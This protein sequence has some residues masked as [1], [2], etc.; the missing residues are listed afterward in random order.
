MSKPYG[1]ELVLDLKGC[2]LTGLGREQVQTFLVD[3]CSLIEMTRHGE[4]MFWEDDSGIEHLHGVSAVQFIETSTVVCHC[5][6]LL[7]AVY[8]N[9]FSC[10]PFDQSE[11]ASFC[12]KFWAAGS[13]EATTISRG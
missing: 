3:L 12:A 2:A 13:V 6:P 10:K 11:T 5:L 8:L 1:I 4:P 9:I 7:E